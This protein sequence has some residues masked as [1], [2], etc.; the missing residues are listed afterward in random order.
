MVFGASRVLQPDYAECLVLT[1]P[2]LWLPLRTPGD[3]MHAFLSLT[4]YRMLLILLQASLVPREMYEGE[5][6]LLTDVV[7][8]RLAATVYVPCI[9]V[10]TGTHAVVTVQTY[11]TTVLELASLNEHIMMKHM[12]QCSSLPRNTYIIT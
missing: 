5:G 3:C 9:T 1:D 10:G 11:H 6:V 12:I 2:R 7:C 4:L 8:S